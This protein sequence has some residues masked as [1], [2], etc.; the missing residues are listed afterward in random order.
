MISTSEGQF[1]SN[2]Y[3]GTN[4][5]RIRFD[6]YEP[7][8]FTTFLPLDGSFDELVIENSKK[9]IKLAKNAKTIKVEAPFFIEG[10]QVFTFNTNKPLVW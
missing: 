1:I 6:N 10:L 4:Y 2:E 9:F 5:V 3:N 7:V 8:K